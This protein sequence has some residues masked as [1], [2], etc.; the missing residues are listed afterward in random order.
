MK[1]T[2]IALSMLVT[3][4]DRKPD[5]KAKV[6]KVNKEVAELREYMQ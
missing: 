1:Y 3:R 5:Y 4:A 2:K 6:Q